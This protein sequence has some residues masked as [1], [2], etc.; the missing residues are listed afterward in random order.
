MTI[1]GRDLCDGSL[2][3]VTS[4]LLAGNEVASI[5]SVSSTQIVVTAAAGSGAIGD[6][7]VTSVKYGQTVA[8]GAFTYSGIGIQVLDADGNLVVADQAASAGAG[9]AFGYIPS[10][11]PVTNWLVITNTGD[12]LVTFSGLSTNGS[13][14]FGIGDD[15]SLPATLAVGH[16]T[17]VPIVCDAGAVGDHTGTLYF[18]N[19]T[20]GASSNYPV[21][22]SASVFNLSTNAGPFQGGQTITITNGVMGTGTD[23]TA[24]YFY[25]FAATILDQGSN[26]V[27]VL[28]P[29]TEWAMTC[30][31]TVRSDSLGDTVLASAYT[32]REQAWIGAINYSDGTWKEMN[33]PAGGVMT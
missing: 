22:L 12:G 3:D 23:I 15:F 5:D 24:V 25:T 19:D 32:F 11:T 30:D 27:Q 9:T 18:I 17:N 28:T 29:A 2:S 1:T 16:T 7:V 8:S 14:V 26:W 20:A 6:V 21:N 4:V 13:D 33:G 31:V 10:G